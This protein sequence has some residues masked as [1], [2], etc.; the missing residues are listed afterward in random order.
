MG[1]FLY[2][3]V[4]IVGRGY[5]HWTMALTGGMILS[6]LYAVN[7]RSSVTLL[8]S[9]MAGSLIIT[10]I[11]LVVGLFDNIIMHWQVWDYS[12]MPLNLFGQICLPFSCFWFVLCI[13]ARYVCRVIRRRFE[14]S[15]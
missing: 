8:R 3:L 12:D 13:P 7:T 15:R 2:S 4:E 9:C 10:G 6:L 14:D 1:F 11:E 5:T